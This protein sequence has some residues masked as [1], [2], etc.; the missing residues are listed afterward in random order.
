LSLI[1][2]NVERKT[3]FKIDQNNRNC[4]PQ[5]FVPFIGVG[6]SQK[7][8]SKSIGSVALNNGLG[9][10]RFGFN[11]FLSS[12]L[13]GKGGMNYEKINVISRRKHVSFWLCFPQRS[14]V[15]EA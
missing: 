14:G 4:L 10:G 11:C 2:I 15:Q 5:V 9:D 8:A 13:G 1:I 12:K 3:S 6:P 7:I